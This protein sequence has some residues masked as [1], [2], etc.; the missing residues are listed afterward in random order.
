[1]IKG[2][3]AFCNQR[4]FSTKNIQRK[5][6]I[7]Y[8][9]IGFH[10]VINENAAK[11]TQLSDTDVNELVEGLWNGTKNLLTR[12]KKGHIPRLLI[13][14]DYSQKGFFIGDLL[15]RLSLTFNDGVKEDDLE[16]IDQFKIN[17]TKLA[18]TLKKYDSKIES[19][20][21]IK[22][23]RVTFTTQIDTK[24][25]TTYEDISI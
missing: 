3:G 9:L 4:N 5:Y 20:T 8:G 25:P 1:L 21:I 12:S 6:N 16:S 14:V 23:D 7:S 15:D 13:K 2:T 19:I 11:H 18:E 22:D 10:G 17:T 24:N